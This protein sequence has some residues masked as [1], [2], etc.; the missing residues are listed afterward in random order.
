MGEA[1]RK[2]EFRN[3]RVPICPF[4]NHATRFIAEWYPGHYTHVRALVI[5][6]DRKL[7]I[8]PASVKK[9]ATH[10]LEPKLMIWLRK[11]GACMRDFSNMNSE[12]EYSY[13]LL[14]GMWH[15]DL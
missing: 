7:Y 11:C 13:D 1:Q 15:P 9:T 3:G 8:V 6:K 14:I 12:F 5:R 10:V 4:C 2:T